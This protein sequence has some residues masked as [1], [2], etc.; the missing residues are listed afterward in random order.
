[1]AARQPRKLFLNLPVRDLERSIAFFKT[2]GFSFNPQF[3]DETAACMVLSED[4]YVMLLTESRFKDFTRKQI[5]DTSKAV[6]GLWALSCE[7]R[8]EVDGHGN[9]NLSRVRLKDGSEMRGPGAAGLAYSASMARR[10]F[11]YMHEHTTRSFVERLDYRTAIGYGEGPGSRERLGLRGGG[12]ALVISP[13][14]VMDFEPATLR[15]R[16]RSVHP[17][18]D[19][20][21][22]VANTGFE[23]V[24]PDAVP[25][26]QAPSARE[27]ELL[28]TQ[29]DCAGVLQH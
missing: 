27:L 11:I 16:L 5:C 14:G 20:A 24:V 2:L 23:L 9:I 19:A 6:E 25:V 21:E 13:R 7:S 28:R 18:Q 12:P 17:G 29:V 10:F 26:T 8:A 15:L 1:M 22:L 3:T 4:A